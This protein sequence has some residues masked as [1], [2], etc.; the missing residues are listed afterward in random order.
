MRTDDRRRTLDVG[1]GAQGLPSAGI[2]RPSSVLNAPRP[3]VVE[4]ADG[5]DGPR[6]RWVLWR[7]RRAVASIDDEWQVDDEWWRAEVSRH[8]FAVTLA[9]G[10]HLTLF[11]DQLAGTW[12]T[13]RY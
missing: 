8:Y 11:H 4:A 2:P 3:L 13:Q 6:P 12:W 7:G 9:D 10:S 1:R 5:P